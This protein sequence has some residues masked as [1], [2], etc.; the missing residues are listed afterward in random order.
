MTH[1]P[2]W[3]LMTNFTVGSTY[4]HYGSAPASIELIDWSMIR[5]FNIIFMRA[6]EIRIWHLVTFRSMGSTIWQLWD[7]RSTLGL[8]A[9]RPMCQKLKLITSF[10]ME[11]AG[12]RKWMYIYTGWVRMC[13]HIPTSCRK[14][15]LKK[16][17]QTKQTKL[18]SNQCCTSCKLTKCT[19]HTNIKHK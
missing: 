18:K 16:N 17:S 7:F 14:L 19:F 8:R 1:T 4:I 15:S 2:F 6:S 3:Q 5:V 9:L 13:I 10:G 11:K 12:S